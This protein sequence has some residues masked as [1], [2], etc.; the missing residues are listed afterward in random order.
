MAHHMADMADT[1]HHQ[2]VLE[3]DSVDEGN[4]NVNLNGRILNV[5]H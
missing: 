2:C 1:C 3:E 4:Y 5:N